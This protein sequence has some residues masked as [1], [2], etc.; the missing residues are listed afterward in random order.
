[1]STQAETPAIAPADIDLMDPKVQENPYDA[2]RQLRDIGVYHLPTNGM[3]VITRYDHIAEIVRN[4]EEFSEDLA[5]HAPPPTT[6]EEMNAIYR[7]KGFERQPTFM[8]DP[9]NHTTYRELIDPFFFPAKLREFE[10]FIQ[11]TIDALIDNFVD[12]GECEFVTDFG[13]PLPAAVI[14]NMLGLPMEDLPK[15]KHYA[16]AWVKPFAM[17]LGRKEKLEATEII[18]E[19]QHYL[20]DQAEK[21]RANPDHGLLSMLVHATYKGLDGT[22]RKLT[23]REVLSFSETAA[24]GGHETTA[25]ALSSGMMLYVQNPDVQRGLAENPAAIK[26]YVEEVLRLESPT[27][28]MF[29]ATTRDVEFHGFTIPKGKIVN[30]RFAAAN[31]D[32]RMFPNAD[33][34]DINRPNAGRHMAFSQ[35]IHHCLGAP[36]ARIELNRAFRSLFGRLKNIRFKPGHEHPEHIPGFTL[37]ALKDLHIS[38]EKA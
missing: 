27:Q 34:I 22:E 37:R 15:L 25:N 16:E 18:C 28:G 17:G 2:Y 26:N 23:T 6:D 33:K 29:R 3:Y 5:A 21:K 8:L 1:M 7:E 19:F 30:L 13:F 35:G 12:R 32:E 24:V 14:T 31:R 10:P 38:F 11:Q 20:V 4:P 36:L 9:P